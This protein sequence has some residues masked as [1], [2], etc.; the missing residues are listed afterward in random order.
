MDNNIISSFLNFNE[1]PVLNNELNIGY[2]QGVN[3]D[4]L[5]LIYKFLGYKVRCL[6]Q[7]VSKWFDDYN[8]YLLVN[9]NIEQYVLKSC[10]EYEYQTKDRPMTLNLNDC[11]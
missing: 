1:T 10:I 8:N 11:S 4:I 7:R 2:L 5:E 6:M 9:P 3:Y